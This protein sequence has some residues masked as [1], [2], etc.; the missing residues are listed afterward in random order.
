MVASLDLANPII[1]LSL[2][3]VPPQLELGREQDKDRL[4]LS[5]A[6]NLTVGNGSEFDECS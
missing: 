2:E 5:Y 1:P 6:D 4:V 3:P